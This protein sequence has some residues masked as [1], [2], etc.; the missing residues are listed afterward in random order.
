MPAK[1]IVKPNRSEMFYH[2]FNR[3]AN[4]DEVFQRPEDYWMWRA[5]SKQ[6]RRL[7]KGAL[8]VD[9]FAVLPTHFHLLVQQL[10]EGAMAS[11]M[12]SLG[13]RYG[14]YFNRTREH[15]GH[16]FEG[17]YK[18][19]MLPTKKDILR[20]RLYILNNPLEFDKF[21]WEHVGNIL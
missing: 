18:A 21:D 19:R 9:T 12:Q 10:E 6:A 11:F 15:S 20:T 7:S 8:I 14:L 2:V 1:F 13:T 4:Q 16:V 5:F 3:G 17:A